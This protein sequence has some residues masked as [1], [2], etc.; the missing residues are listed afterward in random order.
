MTA[1][2]VMVRSHPG[3]VAIEE[4]IRPLLTDPDGLFSVALNLL[5]PPGANSMAGPPDAGFAVRLRPI[6]AAMPP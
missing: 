4:G 6:T 5:P 3:V 2:A 1:T